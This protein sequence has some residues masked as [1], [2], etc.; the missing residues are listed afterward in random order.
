MTTI[1]DI[2]FRRA[3]WSAVFAPAFSL[4]LI[5]QLIPAVGTASAQTP[6]ATASLKE[7]L[8][9]RSIEK[10][11]ARYRCYDA[12]ERGDAPAAA[13]PAPA[14]MPP[15]AVSPT[16]AAAAASTPPAAG[17]AVPDEAMASRDFGLPERR[18]EKKGTEAISVEI[19]S[20]KRNAYGYWIFR[21]SDG[22]VWRQVDNKRAR[23]RQQSFLAEIRKAPITGYLIVPEG[24]KLKMRVRRI[25]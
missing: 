9:C 3:H 17:P 1:V 19:V 13:M 2:I 6:A 18:K 21:T 22:Q 4:V 20:V 24:M 25:K 11:K 12:L 7:F 14:A 8:A 16:A 5:C 23:F 10:R 15:A